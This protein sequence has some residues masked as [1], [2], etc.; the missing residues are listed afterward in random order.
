LHHDNAPSRT[1]FSPGNFWPKET[2]LLS[3]TH[4]TFLFPPIEDKT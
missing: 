1:F 4:P 2:W 3:P